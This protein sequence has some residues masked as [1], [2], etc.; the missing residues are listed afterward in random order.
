MDVVELSDPTRRMG[1]PFFRYPP[2]HAMPSIG[3]DLCRPAPPRPPA[4]KPPGE[5]ARHTEST[6]HRPQAIGNTTLSLNDILKSAG[7]LPIVQTDKNR[8]KQEKTREN[9]SK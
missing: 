7:E 9:E 4:E 1:R 5:L 2:L 3:G 8:R 6:Q